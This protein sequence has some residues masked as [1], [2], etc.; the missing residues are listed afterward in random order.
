M[1]EHANQGPGA[2]REVL[3]RRVDTDRRHLRLFPDSGQFR[4]LE[5]Q[6]CNL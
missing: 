2:D 3:P 6:Q 5:I 1:E 4:F